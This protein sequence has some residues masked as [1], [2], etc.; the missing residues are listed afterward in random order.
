MSRTRAGQDPVLAFIPQ[1]PLK[2][3]SQDLSSDPRDTRYVH[4]F[5]LQPSHGGSERIGGGQGRVLSVAAFDQRLARSRARSG[6]SEATP[7]FLAG[8]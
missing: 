6:T 4:E 7:R 5:S 8:G 2:E 1:P 3:T